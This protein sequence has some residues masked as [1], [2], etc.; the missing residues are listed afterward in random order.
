MENNE[1][2]TRKEPSFALS[3]G[4]IGILVLFV[5]VGYIAMNLKVDIMLICSAVCVSILAMSLGYT[6]KDIEEFICTRLSRTLAT[7]LI[8]W[9]IGTV[10]G[11]F[12]FCGAIPM[13]IRYGVQLIKP[14]LV[15]PMSFVLCA[16]FSTVTG[17][18]WGSAGTAGVACIG[19]ASGLGVS[20]PMTAAAIVCGATFGDKISPLSDTTNLAPLCAGCTLYQHIGSMM[21]TT[22]PA[23]LLALVGF[24][25]LGGMEKVAGSGL[26]Q[27]ALDMMGTLDGMFSWNLLLILPF[28]VIVA[29]AVTKKPPVPTMLAASFVAVLIGVFYQGFSLQ[30]GVLAAYSGFKMDMVPGLD[31]ATASAMVQKLLVRGG[32]TSMAS[33]V[34]II[35]CGY[36]YTSVLSGA[37]F[38]DTAMR[39]VTSRI[40]G[41]GPL[42]AAAF[43]TS[44]VLLALSGITYVSSIC[45]PDMYKRS[46]LEHGMP[47]RVLSRTIED[48]STIMAGLIPWGTSGL[49]YASTLGVEVWGSG[50]YAPYCFTCWFTP[51]IAILLAVTGI[52]IYKM[53][54]EQIRQAL[55]EYD[56]E[57][58]ALKGNA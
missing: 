30:N 44:F 12:M 7:I 33:I 28:L 42:M 11:T 5:G 3:L 53:N 41:R 22:T 19:I 39:P 1:T 13:V 36:A 34:I 24:F 54:D 50:G 14:E 43:C 9:T 46:F 15:I 57:Q 38:M 51:I 4:A 8:I 18:S 35:F 52:G 20:L 25:I 56:A 31:V 37:G 29:G 17:T 58:A 10:I 32:I 23:S 40:R 16:I 47:A 27:E 48:G 49:L 55:A 2:K 6:Y 45:L 26:P 21:W